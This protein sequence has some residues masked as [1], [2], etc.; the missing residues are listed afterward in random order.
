MT[1]LATRL[2]L[3]EK[4]SKK[5]RL[6]SLEAALVVVVKEGTRPQNY[7]TNAVNTL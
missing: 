7:E 2:L 5:K 1:L 3:I 6:P 4:I